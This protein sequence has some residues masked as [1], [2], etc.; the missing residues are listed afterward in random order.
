M[1]DSRKLE[2]RH[3]YIIEGNTTEAGEVDE[4]RI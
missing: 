3:L 2:P 4:S 1:A